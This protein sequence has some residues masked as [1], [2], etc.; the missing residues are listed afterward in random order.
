MKSVMIELYRHTRQLVLHDMISDVRNTAQQLRVLHEVRRHKL[1]HLIRMLC[2]SRKIVT[3]GC[4]HA[5]MIE[6]MYCCVTMKG[7]CSGNSRVRAL[8]DALVSS[9]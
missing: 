8:C 4:R 7:I 5:A 6:A 2:T 9:S 3:A 1:F